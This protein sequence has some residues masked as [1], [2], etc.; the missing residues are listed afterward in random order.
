MRAVVFLFVSLFFHLVGLI[1]LGRSLS[2]LSLSLPSS[3]GRTIE[4]SLYTGQGERAVRKEK[5]VQAAKKVRPPS[6]PQHQLEKTR[7]SPRPLAKK[8]MPSLKGLGKA[9][10]PPP[11]GVSQSETKSG[12]SS[13]EVQALQADTGGSSAGGGEEGRV[14]DLRPRC[15]LCPLP[16]YPLRARQKGWEGEVEVDLV[17]GVDGT[18]THAHLYRSSGHGVL[19]RAALRVAKQSRFTPLSHQTTLRGRIRYWF[20]L[21]DP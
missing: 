10:L 15:L 20:K 2:G 16:P 14:Q 12:P 18:V 4:V 6:S 7:R 21:V 3:E 13:K 1:L 8:T 17:L 11:S 5:R 9:V 19:D